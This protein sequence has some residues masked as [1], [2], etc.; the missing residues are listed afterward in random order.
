MIG[1]V[2]VIFVFIM[3]FSWLVIISFDGDLGLDWVRLL[4]IVV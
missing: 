3:F 1:V 2:V 4:L